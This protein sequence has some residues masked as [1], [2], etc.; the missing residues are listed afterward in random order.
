MVPGAL[1]TGPAAWAPGKGS[2]PA[3]SEHPHGQGTPAPKEGLPCVPEMDR[4]SKAGSNGRTQNSKARA[5]A[6][7]LPPHSAQCGCARARPP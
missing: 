5:E 4:K 2:L 7:A 3:P 6:E 1:H